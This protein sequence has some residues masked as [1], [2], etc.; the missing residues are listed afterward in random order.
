MA[1]AMF[2]LATRMMKKEAAPI[3]TNVII[4][5]LVEIGM[6]SLNG[7]SKKE[8]V[9]NVKRLVQECL[10]VKQETGEANVCQSI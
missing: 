8:N 4:S 6:R 3:V 7:I 10:M 2:I 9:L 1:F 5:L